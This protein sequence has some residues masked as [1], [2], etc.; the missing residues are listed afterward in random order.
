[1]SIF[2]IPL[3]YDGSDPSINAFCLIDIDRKGCPMNP[4]WITRGAAPMH[5]WFCKLAKE[6]LHNVDAAGV[7][8]QW[9]VERCWR[10]FG[11][12]LGDHPERRVYGRAYSIAREMARERS[13]VKWHLAHP[14]ALHSGVPDPNDY[15]ADIERRILVDQIRR[16]LNDGERRAVDKFLNGYSWEEIAED[17]ETTSELR[18]Y[19]KHLGQYLARNV[20]QKLLNGRTAVK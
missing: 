1:M 14:V 10:C 9:A 13:S 2:T 6:W 17:S 7:I 15:V 16:G 3:N 8:A 20:R 5:A 18:R 11:N 12:E 19:G 4:A